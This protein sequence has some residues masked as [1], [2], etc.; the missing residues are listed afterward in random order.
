M[1]STS[2]SKQRVAAKGHTVLVVDDEPSI[3]WALEKMLTQEGHSVVTA[4]SAEEGLERASEV[5]PQ[6]VILDVRLPKED[7]ITAL[8]KF[9]AAT[10]QA[11]VVVITAFGDLET[12][13]AAVKNGATDY[14]TKPFKLEDALRVCRQALADTNPH[15]PAVVATKAPVN[16]TAIIGTSPAMQ[17]V[18]R[19]IALVAESDLSVLITGETGTGKELV[20]AAIHRHSRRS[21]GP[22]LPIAPV[23]LNPDLIESELFG[24][25]KGAFT[26]ASDD[27]A[28]LFERAEGGTVLL[29]E[30]GD[31]PLGTQVKL[32]R[33]LEQGQ[34][35]R[36]GDVRTR[37]ANVRI[38]AATNC[39]LHEAVAEGTF[40][41]DLFH[42]M[43]GMQIHLPPLRE[44]S[45]DLG[46][47]CQHFL[48]GVQYPAPEKAISD[49]LLAELQK[50]PWHG[51]V[52]ELKNAVEHAAVLARSRPLSIHDFPPPAPGRGESSSSPQG[53]LEKSIEQWALSSLQSS[54]E[55]PQDLHAKFLAATEPTLFKIILAHTGG[56]RAKASEILGIHRGTLRDRLRSYGMDET[57]TS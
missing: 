44:R 47:L 45:V 38:L 15:T 1:T 17:Q 48:A 6:L 37:T 24:H 19:Q 36:V 29:D 26:G 52:R 35:S 2:E 18:F 11:P 34:Y 25:V 50:Q 14:L 41:E 46:L 55:P 40:R 51:N 57:D 20:A 33:V 21:D 42:R 12:A 16:P 13:V 3:C 54:D 23:A 5:Q 30:I 7:G 56:N 4:S 10:G 53:S 31:L 39:D 28:G 9:L 49:E 8:P 43:T 22:Y 32:L 27:R